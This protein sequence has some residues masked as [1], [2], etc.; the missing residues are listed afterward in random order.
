M[1]FVYNS[2]ITVFVCFLGSYSYVDPRYQ[3]RTVQ[4]TADKNGF[5]PILNN[6]P[7][8]LPRDSPVVAAAKQAHLQQYAAIADANAG[9]IVVPVD[10]VAVA[11]AKNKHFNLYEKIAQEHARIAAERA[12]KTTANELEE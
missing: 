11:R 7:P 8:P 10:T 6:Q 5:H 1:F 9:H 12:Q 2:F 3:I 4:Y